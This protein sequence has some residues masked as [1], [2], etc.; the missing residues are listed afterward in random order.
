MYEC[1]RGSRVCVVYVDECVY[2]CER[3]S[4]VCVVYVDESVYECER[5][6][7]VCMVYVDRKSTRLN[8]SHIRTHTH[9]HTPHTF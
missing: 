8:P 3:G 5:G 2:E 4:R 7:S 1:E 6:S 9:P